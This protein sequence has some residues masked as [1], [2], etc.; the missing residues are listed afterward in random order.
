MKRAIVCAMLAGALALGCGG[1]RKNNTGDAPQASKSE[2][3]PGDPFEKL[4]DDPPLNANTRF[5]AGQLAEAQGDA[6]RAIAQYREALKLDP[7][8]QQTLFRLGA[9]QTQLKRYP[10]AIV[11]WQR[12]IKATNEAPAAY[13]NLA[14]CYE[15]A[16]R[17]SDAEETFKAGIE[18]D[19]AVPTCRVNYGLML[20]RHDRLDDA[21]A[22]LRMV[23]SPAEVHYNLGAVFEQKGQR[24][25]AKAS[26]EKALELD[27]RLADARSR[28]AA[29]K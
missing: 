13:N 25:Q 26:Y 15:L 6:E 1:N 4:T 12:Y 21:V 10:D 19:P 16:G 20:A 14:F 22:Q 7:D 5:A 29:L 3:R 23:L 17:L 28:L 8:H 24:E 11:T 18:R 2:P 27:P 9:L